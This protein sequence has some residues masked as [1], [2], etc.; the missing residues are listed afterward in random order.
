[1]ETVTII[2]GGLAALSLALSLRKQ[3]VPCA[4]YE[5]RDESYR[6]GGDIALA[7]NALR[8]LDHVGAYGKARKLGYNYDTFEMMNSA[9]KSLGSFR[10]GGQDLFSYS[11]LRINRDVVRK[12]LIEE[13]KV[14]RI[15]IHFNKKCVKVSESEDQVMAHFED[16]EIVSSKFLVGA[17]GIHSRVRQYLYPGSE[18]QYSGLLV[19]LGHTTRDKIAQTWDGA[20]VPCMYFGKDGAFTILPS[21]YNGHEV[22]YFATLDVPDRGEEWDRLETDKEQIGQIFEEV[23]QDAS[24]PTI[25][26]DLLKA[27]ALPDFRSW[28]FAKVPDLENYVST[29]GRIILVGDAAHAIPPSGGQGAAMAFED[30]ETLSYVL[31][32]S[33]LPDYNQA[34]VTEGLRKWE[35]HRIQ[36]MSEILDYTIRAGD[37]RK[38]SSMF[39]VQMMKE[40]TIWALFKFYKYRGGGPGWIYNYNAENILGVVSG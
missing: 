23:V 18:A 5:L 22:G 16:G 8:V 3:D 10:N 27:T 32:K 21:S 38:R 33:S 25:V 36:R 2:G 40:W 37:M 29:S 30:A 31:G 1:M 20:K 9:G 14:Q 11:A 19:V 4:I 35:K 15:P 12:V 6:K 28:P 26:K 17:D 7:P 24:W 39:L 34:K 13:V